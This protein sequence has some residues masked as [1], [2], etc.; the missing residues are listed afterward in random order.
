MVKKFSERYM[1]S[2]RVKK[3]KNYKLLFV[4]NQKVFLSTF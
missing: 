2:I 3:V 1:K 4:I